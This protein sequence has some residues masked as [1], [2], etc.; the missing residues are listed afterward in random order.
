MNMI[1]DRIRKEQFILSQHPIF[2][3]PTIQNIDELRTFMESHVYAVW[4]F[5]SLLKTLQHTLAPTT[6]DRKSTRLNSSHT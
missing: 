3:K 5:M 6:V 2:A 4:D 1:L